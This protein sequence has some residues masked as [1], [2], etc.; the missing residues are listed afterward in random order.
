MFASF[1]AG[2]H[3]APF[4]LKN[5]PDVAVRDI[6]LQA[7]END[8]LMAT[9]GRGSVVILDDATPGSAD[10]AAARRGILFPIR[11]A[12]RYSVARDAFGRRRTE[13]AAPNPPTARS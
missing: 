11:P 2:E 5:L 4:G 8:I 10:G 7:D 3:W 1:D 9:H 13:F 6:F 12:L